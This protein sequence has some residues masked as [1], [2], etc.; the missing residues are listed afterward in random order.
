VSG[1]NPQIDYAI[2][3]IDRVNGYLK[4][5]I[6]TTVTFEESRQQLKNMFD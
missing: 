6:E 5:D 3:M 4:Q 1:S 2:D